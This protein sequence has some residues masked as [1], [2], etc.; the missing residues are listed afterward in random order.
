MLYG[1]GVSPV[2]PKMRN[3][4]DFSKVTLSNQMFGESDEETKLL[5]EYFDEAAEY[6]NFYDWHSGIK[7]SYFGMGIGG[8]FSVFLFE[9]NPTREDVDDYVWVVVG[10]IPPAYI[11]CENAPNPATA[12]DG[13]IGAMSG[14]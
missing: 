6:L 8:I 1:L 13:Y 14:W 10:D 9:I 3:N 11:T 7:E 12:I 2:M 5:K 4:I